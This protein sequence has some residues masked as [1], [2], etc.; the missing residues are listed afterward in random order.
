MQVQTNSRQIN[1]IKGLWEST[2]VHCQ[3]F[4]T[5]CFSFTTLDEGEIQ[6][7]ATLLDF[8]QDAQHYLTSANAKYL[9]KCGFFWFQRYSQV[10]KKGGFFERGSH[11]IPD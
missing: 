9:F 1:P 10:K 2:Q 8:C 7:K 3:P 11:H 6:F 4:K 5:D